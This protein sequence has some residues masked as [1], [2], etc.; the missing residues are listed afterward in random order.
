MVS[1]WVHAKTVKGEQTEYSAPYYSSN[2]YFMANTNFNERH[3]VDILIYTCNARS[4]LPHSQSS[5]F[6]EVDLFFKVLF[7]FFLLWLL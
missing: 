7:S 3:K 1:A 2:I 6:T 4:Q 5:Q